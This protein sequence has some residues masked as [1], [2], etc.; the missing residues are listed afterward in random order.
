MKQKEQKEIGI[1]SWMLLISN[2]AAVMRPEAL[3]ASVV[4][5]LYMIFYSRISFLDVKIIL[6]E[7]V[8][9]KF[10]QKVGFILSETYLIE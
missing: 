3:G 5:S 4:G 7:N 1:F 9:H 2:T 8:S 6:S 10:V